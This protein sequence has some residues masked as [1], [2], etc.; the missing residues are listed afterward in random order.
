LSFYE[1]L[2]QAE[3]CEES[4]VNEFLCDLP[5][6]LEKDKNDLESV[7]IFSKISKAVLELNSG[8]SLSIDGLTAEFNKRFWNLMDTNSKEGSLGFFFFEKLAPC[9][10]FNC[11]FEDLVKGYN[12]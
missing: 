3:S 12:K 6:I 2:Y 9:I 1:K 7:L 10:T 8:K 4:A 5:Q 11:G